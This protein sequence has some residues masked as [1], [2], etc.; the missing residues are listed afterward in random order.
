MQ[1]Y[2]AR[3]ARFQRQQAVEPPFEIGAVDLQRAVREAGVIKPKILAYR[4]NGS[5]YFSDVTPPS[6]TTNRLY[7]NSGNLYWAGNL[8]GGA[9]TG[10]WTSDGTNV[11][12]TGG[13]IGI[14]TS[15]PFSML[16]V[17]GNGY[18]SGNLSAAG[19]L[20][21]SGLTTLGN[22]TTSNLELTKAFTFSGNRTYAGTSSPSNSFMFMNGSALFG[23]AIP[24]PNGIISPFN[25]YISGDQVDT[26]TNGNGDLI[27][28]SVLTAASAN[29]TGGR[30]RR[31]GFFDLVQKWQTR[32]FDAS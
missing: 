22:A 18:F 31:N 7:S 19:T 11:W 13:N 23:T 17:N 25:I 21:V 6:I 10:N 4:E 2:S 30:E 27:G 12:R 9:T 14:G 8:L 26:T 28:F 20:A 32:K 24:A 5:F 3:R 16:S 15:S 29:H 1:L